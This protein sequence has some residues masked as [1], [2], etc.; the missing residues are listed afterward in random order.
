M[1]SFSSVED[2]IIFHGVNVI[3]FEGL[4]NIRVLTMLS[5]FRMLSFMLSFGVIIYFMLSFGVIIYFMLSFDVI[6]FCHHL[7]LSF[8][9]FFLFPE[10]VT[11]SG[12]IRT[13][14]SI[15]PKGFIVPTAKFHI[16]STENQNN[17]IA[18]GLPPIEPNYKCEYR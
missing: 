15:R 1:L 7:L 6:I 17:M 2:V 9:P 13:A 16:Q 12:N 18:N 11:H 3:I 10:N 8:P 4:D 14:G 5:F